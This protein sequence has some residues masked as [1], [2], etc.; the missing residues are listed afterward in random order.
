MF[1]IIDNY[2]SFVYNL[3]HYFEELGETVKVYR[4]DL[5][6]IDFIKSLKPLGIIISPG[7]KNP[8]ETGICEN[9][10]REFS[11]MI[12][13]L[14]VCL[15]HQTI[16]H[17]FGS[18]IIKGSQPMHGKV[19]PIW[20]NQEGVFKGLP[21]PLKVTRYH[22]LVVDPKTLP[23]DFI[24]TAKSKDGAIMGIRHHSYILEGVQFHPEA[25]LTQYGHKMLAN[26]I[27]ECKEVNL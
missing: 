20:H 14:G 27:H 24:I 6:S 9:V 11:G 26:F 19:T 22:S 18:Q 1:L 4:N 23:T 15:G 17:V 25:V 10:I 3:A 16:A 13:I 12:P 8:T 7:P 21:T 5:I 2:D